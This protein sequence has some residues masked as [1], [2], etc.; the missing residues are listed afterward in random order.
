LRNLACAFLSTE[1]RE[2]NYGR[3]PLYGTTSDVCATGPIFATQRA[4]ELPPGLVPLLQAGGARFRQEGLPRV[5]HDAP[6]LP[7]HLVLTGPVS[8]EYGYDRARGGYPLAL[9]VLSTPGMRL[10]GSPLDTV[11]PRFWPLSLTEATQFETAHGVSRT[12]PLHFAMEVTIVGPISA[13]NGATRDR[14]G[15]PDGQMWHFEEG[16]ISLYGDAA[17]THLLHTFNASVS[18]IGPSAT[19]Q[20]TGLA[21]TTTAQQDA[22]EAARRWDLPAVQG[23]PVVMAQGGST[24][25]HLLDLDEKEG[26][27]GQLQWSRAMHAL[28]LSVAPTQ[29]AALSD[30]DILRYARL[31]LPASRLAAI[32]FGQRCDPSHPRPDCEFVL[33]D[34]AATFRAQDLPKA[35]Q[36]APKLPM[37][38]LLVIQMYHRPWDPTR[39]GFPLSAGALSTANPMYLTLFGSALDTPLLDFWPAGEAEARAYVARQ[40]QGPAGPNSNVYLAMPLT[41]TGVHFDP[42]PTVTSFDRATRLPTGAE[43]RYEPGE[44]VLY[45]DAAVTQKLYAYGPPRRLAAPLIGTTAADKPRPSGPVAL[46]NDTAFLL[47][48]RSGRLPAAW[49]AA[50]M[51]RLHWEDGLR[52]K[53][54]FTAKDAWGIFFD[55]PR[56][57]FGTSPDAPEVE[58][59]RRWSEKRAATL[60]EDFQLSLPVWSVPGPKRLVLFNSAGY[61]GMLHTAWPFPEG[62]DAPRNIAAPLKQLGIATEQVLPISFRVD[63]YG[64][65]AFTAAPRPN[66]AYALDL[67]QGVPPERAVNGAAAMLRVKVGIDGIDTVAHDPSGRESGVLLRLQPIEA[68]LETGQTTLASTEYPLTKWASPPPETPPNDTVRQSKPATPGG[69]QGPSPEARISGA[70]YGPDALGVRL[71]MTM[72]EAEALVRKHMSVSAVLETEAPAEGNVVAPIAMMRGKVFVSNDRPDPQ[73]S[74]QI[75]IFEAPPHAAG[76]V[77]AIWRTLYL[78]NGVWPSVTSQLIEKYGAPHPRLSL[79]P[80]QLTWTAGSAED[81]KLHEVRGPRWAANAAFLG[82]RLE[83]IQVLSLPLSG[84]DHAEALGRCGPMVEVSKGGPESLADGRPLFRFSTKLFDPGVLAWLLG[85]YAI[86]APTDPGARVKL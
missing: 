60:P 53:L 30:Q 59:F 6:K 33:R 79:P 13:P 64:L 57:S 52:G 61:F 25:L 50:A 20:P 29:A 19:L 67:P 78:D 71:G 85:R 32:G 54:D 63:G 37:R 66:N 22:G 23:A 18:Q 15:L 40:K 28:G 11:T 81:C 12:A 47:L 77:V 27:P 31:Y 14:T 49:E 68:R 5:V 43:W 48:L 38:L 24:F 8:L 83:K 41:I 51:D 35:L 39:G 69:W 3:N 82:R 9:S 1:Q 16:P 56:N 44:P 2:A 70:P 80:Q 42:H 73:F 21:P 58:A 45:A 7:L 34:E 46:N 72:A 84:V 86:D 10:F 4:A 26:G 62:T 17:L 74:E 75:A 65:T 76:K 36:S 55:R